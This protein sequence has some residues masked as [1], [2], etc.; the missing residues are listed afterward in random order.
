MINILIAEDKYDVRQS[1][2]NIFEINSEIRIIGAADNGLEV[3]DMAK[4]LLPDLILMDIKLPGQNGLEATRQIKEFCAAN[5][6]DIKIL[7]LSTFYDDDFVLKSQEYGVDGYLLKGLPPNKLISAI[8][9]ACSGLVTL[10]RVIYDKQNSLVNS[11]INN[12]PELDL[13]TKTELSILKLLAKGKS[14]ADIASALF[15]SEGTVRNSISSMMSKL[16]CNNSRDLVVFG[17]KARL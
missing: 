17:I 10:D 6:C 15:F 4:I 2:V 8:K 7:I 9:N 11:S 13:L 14:N 1:L 5:G 16:E 12:R 3:V